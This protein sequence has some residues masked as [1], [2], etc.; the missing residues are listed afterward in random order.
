MEKRLYI[1]KED[2][3][4]N[5][6]TLKGEEFMHLSKVMR[7]RV[8]DTAECFYN[9]SDIFYCKIERIEKNSAELEIVDS[10]KCIANPDKEVVLFQALPKLDKLE[11]VA[12]KVCELGVSRIVPFESRFT[13]AKPNQNKLDRLEKIS[14]S[15]CKQCGRTALLG[16]DGTITFKQL[17]TQI[18]DFDQVILAN[19]TENTNALNEIKGNKIAIIVGSEGGFAKEEI[20]ELVKAGAISVTLGKRILRTE[21]ASVVL[22]ALVLDRLGELRWKYVC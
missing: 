16:I 14:I 4:G 8:G 9:G 17:L 5:S 13:V 19:E 2:V 22:S 11:M 7:M 18:K 10:Y 6:I 15:A 21:T 1:E 20:E 12:Q 3:C